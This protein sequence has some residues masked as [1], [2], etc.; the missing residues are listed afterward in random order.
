M[1][2]LREVS[3]VSVVIPCHCCAPTIERAVTSVLDQTHPPREV[4]LVDD[5]SPDHGATRA[6]LAKQVAR[7]TGDTQIG[8]IEL[9]TNSGPSTARNAGWDAATQPLIA[10]LDADDAWHPRKL[11]I[12]AAWMLRNAHAALTG[13]QQPIQTTPAEA[14][15][16]EVWRVDRLSPR[17]FLQR[18]RITTSSAMLRRELPYRFTIG[19]RRCED[20]LL[21]NQIV[22]DGHPV[23]RIKLP[24]AWMY[25]APL[26]AAGLSADRARMRA[27]ELAMYWRLYREQRIRLAQ[28]ATLIPLSLAK[29]GVSLLR[30]AATPTVPHRGTP[31]VPRAN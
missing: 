18:N 3:P 30:R 21:W 12:Q 27:G 19:L 23:F 16:P 6:A 4:W 31:L 28:L 20:Y 13:H 25:K 8:L 9:S 1:T 2:V 10:F 15:L 5:A 7:S 26:G 11:E 14:G 24:L 17:Q 29:H 22:L